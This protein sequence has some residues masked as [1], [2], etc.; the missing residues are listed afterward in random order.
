MA[1]SD[2]R[3][4]LAC[5][6]HTH[7]HTLRLCFRRTSLWQTDSKDT[8]KVYIYIYIQV[9]PLPLWL[10]A[11]TRDWNTQDRELTAQ[12]MHYALIKVVKKRKKSKL[13]LVVSIITLQRIS[14]YKLW[15]SIINYVQTYTCGLFVIS[16]GNGYSVILLYTELL[17]ILLASCCADQHR[18]Y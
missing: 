6:T 12:S 3:F 15:I 5:I 16:V 9:F 13:L 8:R 4:P 18:Q 10:C 7:T 1:P 11:I 14:R 17:G 2:R